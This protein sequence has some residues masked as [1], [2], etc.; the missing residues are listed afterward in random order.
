MEKYLSDTKG[1]QIDAKDLPLLE[2]KLNAMREAFIVWDGGN[3]AVAMAKDDAY[4]LDIA[5]TNAA[6]KDKMEAIRD[7]I[8]KLFK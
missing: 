4:S 6:N 7:D 2:E 3:L 1:K 8:L 5:R